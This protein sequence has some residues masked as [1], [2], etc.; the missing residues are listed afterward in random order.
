[1]AQQVYPPNVIVRTICD[2]FLRHR[3]LALAPWNLVGELPVFSDDRVISDMEQFGYIRI[4]ALR[5][6]PRGARDWVVVLVLGADSKHA[7][8]SPDIRKLLGSVEIE[9]PAKDGRLDEVILVVETPFFTKKNLTDVVR[10]ARPERSG[11]A[12]P[13]GALPFYNVY[14]Y[15][16]FA[17]VVPEHVSVAPHRVLSA[18]ETEA[19][20]ARE[21]LQ[22]ENLPVIYAN[23]PPIVWN[24]GREGQVVEIL[25]DSQ[26]SGVA[27]YYRRIER[28]PY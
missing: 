26:L 12:D 16:N 6:E 21:R 24:G 25:R 10:E 3:G 20:L 23:D 5:R 1:M 22:R 7:H 19:F 13:E 27:P 15:H 14:P 11:G 2:A 8:H 17:L 28:S 9:R 4:D 18:A